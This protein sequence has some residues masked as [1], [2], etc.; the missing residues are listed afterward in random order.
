MTSSCSPE[1]EKEIRIHS[2]DPLNQ[3][4]PVPPSC[5]SSVQESRSSSSEWRQNL[6]NIVCGGLAGI[7]AKTAVAPVERLKIMFQVTNEVYALRKFP[8]IIQHIIRT[9]GNEEYLFSLFLS[10]I[11]SQHTSR[12]DLTK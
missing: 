3:L 9:D 12:I 6:S 4:K 10:T 8:S 11:S 1:S 2:H 7:L 5:P